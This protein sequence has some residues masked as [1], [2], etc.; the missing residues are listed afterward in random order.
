MK[1]RILLISLFT[2][3]ALLSYAYH[4]RF[5]PIVSERTSSLPENTIQDFEVGDTIMLLEPF[6]FESGRYELYFSF[7]ASDG[8]KAKLLSTKDVN[9]L[10][11]LKKSMHFT[12][13]GGDMATCESFLYLMENDQLVLKTG[14]VLG[15][16]AGIQ[17]PEYGWIEP[18]DV[19]SIQNELNQLSP[20][21]WPLVLI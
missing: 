3:L 16:Q 8:Q 4:I 7:A 10:N 11:R 20:R 17:S 9:V 2:T 12:Y 21:Y 18:L 14:I 5:L 6:R 19:Q 15:A 1:Q 13:T